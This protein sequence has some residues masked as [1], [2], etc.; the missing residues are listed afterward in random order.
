MVST[1]PAV[2]GPRAQPPGWLQDGLQDGTNRGQQN[3]H[4]SRAKGG[5]TTAALGS[6]ANSRERRHGLL[7]LAGVVAG[8]TCQ[9]ETLEVSANPTACS[10]GGRERPGARSGGRHVGRR[11]SAEHGRPT[12]RATGAGGSVPAP[13]PHPHQVVSARGVGC[14]VRA[15]DAA[16]AHGHR[17]GVARAALL[18]GERLP[19]HRVQPRPGTRCPPHPRAGGRSPRP[20]IGQ[21]SS[22]STH[23]VRMPA[24]SDTHQHDPPPQQH[25]LNRA[26]RSERHRGRLSLSPAPPAPDAP[27]LQSAEEPVG[28]SRLHTPRARDRVLFDLHTSASTAPEPSTD[29]PHLS[30]HPQRRGGLHDGGGPA[31]A[32]GP[33]RAA[34]RL[35]RY[36]F[37]SLARQLKSPAGGWSQPPATAEIGWR[38]RGPSPQRV[39]GRRRTRPTPGRGRGRRR[40]RGAS[41]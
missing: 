5:L 4:R 36:R 39:G 35:G 31:G 3:R 7:R 11:R 24:R 9:A 2:G 8:R 21:T 28:P 12:G 30:R 22:P 6:Q 1:S 25:L 15:D 16:T 20:G 18:G 19:R 34:D 23:P 17:G 27:R 26:V 38:D 33:P 37:A 40:A 13:T 32:L 29:W 41:G 10:R 14:A